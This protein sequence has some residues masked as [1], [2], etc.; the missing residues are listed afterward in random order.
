MA[1]PMGG[2]FSLILLVAVACIVYKVYSARQQKQPV[3][4]AAADKYASLQ[5]LE[6]RLVRGEINIEEFEKLKAVL[7]L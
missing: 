7:Q 5:I 6:T 3:S 1:P 4:S 2:I